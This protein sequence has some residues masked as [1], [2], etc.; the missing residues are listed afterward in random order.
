M[1][2]GVTA[3][4]ANAYFIFA[5]ALF[6]AMYCRVGVVAAKTYRYGEIGSKAE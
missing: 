1:P 5:I 3:C 2:D 6:S 4:Q